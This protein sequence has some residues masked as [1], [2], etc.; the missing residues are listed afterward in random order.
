MSK[1]PV[2]LSPYNETLSAVTGVKL[3]SLARQKELLS[4]HYAE[5][6]KNAAAAAS[7]LQ[8]LEILYK[9]I[10]ECPVSKGT[11]WIDIEPVSAMVQQAA[12]DRSMGDVVLGMW[13]TR[14]ERSIEQ[15]LK[16]FEY[17]YLFDSVLT[18][19]LQTDGNTE[20]SVKGDSKS[21]DGNESFIHTGRAEGIQQREM[22]EDMIFSEA[23]PDLPRFHAFLNKSFA[24]DGN[25]DGEGAPKYSQVSKKE[26]ALL[27]REL[28]RIRQ[29]VKGFGKKLLLYKQVNSSDVENAIMGLLV[30]DC[31]GEDKRATCMEIKSSSTILQEIASVINILLRDLKNW[32]WPE[33]GVNIRLLR[34]LNGR[35]RA[36][37]D[38]ELLT[39]IFLQF[40]GIEWSAHFR[41]TL[42]RLMKRQDG[43]WK[44]PKSALNPKQRELHKH[45]IEDLDDV[46]GLTDW[47][48]EMFW[49]NYFMNLLPT[50]AAA[51]VRGYNE[52]L[53]NIAA[54]DIPPE[55]RNRA[56]AHELK[57][58][59]LHR[60][61]T[62]VRFAR[63]V[64]PDKPFT[65]VHADL[66]MF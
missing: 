4:K 57:Q 50:S 39:A 26:K 44:R 58:Q 56:R 42:N 64:H 52:D 36:Y 30:G 24:I 12:Q 3:K 6:R 31:L 1:A 2:S 8:R 17:A 48:D 65:V 34:Q 66:K 47:R 14:L 9:G 60:I 11:A 20:T 10:K 63:K 16:K 46:E 45:M 33:E 25:V 21:K 7:Q 35:Y 51:G 41:N 28:E 43:G 53:E 38:E 54:D 27:K 61:I 40:V 37:L 15:L 5:I 23:K 18:E 55:L 49:E 32:K 22:I 13:C 19:W 62:E 59:M 29:G